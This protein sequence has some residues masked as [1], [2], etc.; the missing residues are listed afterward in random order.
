MLHALFFHISIASNISAAPLSMFNDNFALFSGQGHD[1]VC[2]C[3]C[4]SGG[5]CGGG[6]C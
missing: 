3:D 6:G 4:D 5:G 2:D 1:R